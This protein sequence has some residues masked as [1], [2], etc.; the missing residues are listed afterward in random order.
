MASLEGK[1]TDDQG[2][3]TPQERARIEAS[4]RGLEQAPSSRQQLGSFANWKQVQ[5]QLGQPFNNERIPLNKLKLMRR[6]PMLGFGMHFT[7]TPMVRAPIYIKSPDPELA[8]FLDGAIRPIWASYIVQH[9]QKYDF[10]F[11]AMAKRFSFQVP[12]GTWVDPADG[13]EKPVWTANPGNIQPVTLKPFVPLP[14]ESV[15]PI[16]DPTSGEFAGIN[17]KPPSGGGA[18][19]GT[20]G[21]KKGAGGSEGAVEIDLYHALWATNEQDSVFGN[22]FGY[23]R[24]GYAYPYW[25]SYWFRWAIADRAFERKGDPATVV[26]HPEGQIDLGNGNVVSNAEYALLIGER[27]RSGAAVA[28]P[29]TPYFG[30]DDKPSNVSEWSIDFLKGGTELEPFDKSFDYLDVQKLRAIWVPEQA[31]IEGG[32]GTSSR[33][34][35]SEM[36][37]AMVDAQSIGMEEVISDFNRFVVPHLIMVNFPEK[38]DAGVR[39]SVATRGFTA[40]DM[41]LLTLVTQLVGQA[42]VGELGVDIRQALSQHGLPMLS[43]QQYQ[44]KL[45]Q[46]AAAA[47]AAGPGA[48]APDRGAAGVVPTTGRPPATAA[49]APGADANTLSAT[50]FTYIPAVD[51]IELSSSA[52][53]FNENLPDSMHYR[54]ESVRALS[55]QLWRAMSDLYRDQ[56][57]GFAEYLES[58]EGDALHLSDED[59]EAFEFAPSDFMRDMARRIVG[60]FSINRE[61]LDQAMFRVGQILAA[62]MNRAGHLTRREI[63]GEEELD[64]RDIDTWTGNRVA[65]AISKTISTTREEIE[66]F[67]ANYIETGKLDPKELASQ[68]RAHFSDFP[69][70]K[71]ARYARADTRDAYN[72]AR[73]LTGKANGLEVV[74]AHDAQEGPSDAECEHRD[75]QFYT[76]DQALREQEHPNG[77]LE[78]AFMKSPVHVS[79]VAEVPSEV[80]GVL[81]SWDED[82]H[83]IYLSNDLEDPESKRFMRAVGE[84]LCLTAT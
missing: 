44:A 52:M 69:E 17:F 5:N 15:E 10:G 84:K 54:D 56:Y 48:V 41:E 33:N 29:S 61:K 49:N 16:F 68:I 60:E 50:G 40:Q 38:W 27:L 73:L 7:K 59:Q 1:K 78:W 53:D 77:T 80:P 18:P 70:W 42:N 51:V 75:L 12:E 28:L 25:W 82:S 45:A 36:Q 83:T 76:I 11:Q 47:A 2:L 9:L 67:V 58:Y 32:G 72:A 19:A 66:N 65:D 23:P 62:I 8:G 20:G 4:I 43:E 35:A 37:S 81:A 22:I 34:V 24:L 21:K 46:S 13:V 55:R 6:D 30:L 74:Q 26:R 39:A 63:L 3:I 14:P 31:L 64:S 71:A 79:R 57:D